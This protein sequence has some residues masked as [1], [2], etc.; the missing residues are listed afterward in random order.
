M[1]DF[2][3]PMTFSER[4]FVYTQLARHGMLAL[5]RQEPLTAVFARYEVVRLHIAQE[6]TWP[7]GQVSPAHE[8]YPSARVWGRDGWTFFTEPEAQRHFERLLTREGNL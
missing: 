6:H 7:N 5:Y 4:G 2:T 8:A 3:L 1:T